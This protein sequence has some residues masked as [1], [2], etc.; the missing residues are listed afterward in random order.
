MHLMKT[1]HL[2]IALGLVVTA[3]AAPDA[4]LAAPDRSDAN[5]TT[6]NADAATLKF[7]VDGLERVNGA[8]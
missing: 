8:L 4:L 2:A 5:S 1:Q 6:A 3:A 7:R